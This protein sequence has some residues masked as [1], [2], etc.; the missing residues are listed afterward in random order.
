MK[1][2]KEYAKLK[3]DL[4]ESKGKYPL[5]IVISLDSFKDEEK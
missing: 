1:T 5:K 4:E 3:N 2:E